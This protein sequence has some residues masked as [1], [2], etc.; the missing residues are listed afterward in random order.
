MTKNKIFDW[1]QKNRKEAD[2]S[3]VASHFFQ[4]YFKLKQDGAGQSHQRLILI[5]EKPH[6]CEFIEEVFEQLIET[7]D[8]FLLYQVVPSERGEGEGEKQRTR[9]LQ[10]LQ[11]TNS[12]TL[13]V[14]HD[15]ALEEKVPPLSWWKDSQE[16][17]Q[18]FYSFLDLSRIL[19]NLGFSFVKG[20]ERFAKGCVRFSQKACWI[21]P[22][23]SSQPLVVSKNMEGFEFVSPFNLFPQ[24][25]IPGKDEILRQENDW[26]E[27]FSSRYSYFE[28]EDILQLFLNNSSDRWRLYLQDDLPFLLKPFQSFLSEL[29]GQSLTLRWK[30]LKKTPSNWFQAWPGQK[31]RS[32]SPQKTQ[33]KPEQSFFPFYFYEELR[34]AFLVLDE[35]QEIWIRSRGLQ[36]GKAHSWQLP[37]D[38]ASANQ[39]LL[40]DDYS[41][42]LSVGDSVIHPDYGVARFRGLKTL[43]LNHQ[44]LDFLLLEFDE[45][46]KLSLS[47]IELAQFRRYLPKEQDVKLDS[48]R[49]SQWKKRLSRVRKDLKV[50]VESVLKHRQQ[51]LQQNVE[52][53]RFQE[54]IWQE[55]SEQFPHQLTACQE[56]AIRDVLADFESGRPMLRLLAGDVGFGKTEVAWQVSYAVMCHQ[57]QVLLLAP[58]TVL[59]QQHFQ[60]AQERFRDTGV[61]IGLLTGHIKGKQKEE[62]FQKLAH[63]EIDLLIATHSV[64]KKNISFPALSLLIVDEEHKFGVQQKEFLYE[65]FPL[66]HVLSMSATPIPRTLSLALSGMMDLSLLRTPPK[67]RKAIVNVIGPFDEKKVAEALQT[68]FERGGQSFFVSPRIMDLEKRE[69]WLKLLLPHLK[70]L[71]VHGDLSSDLI[72]SRMEDF[73]KGRGDVLLSTILIEAGMDFPRANTIVID[74]SEY[75]GLAQLYQLRGR[76]GRRQTQAY[77]YI[78]FSP[79]EDASAKTKVEARLE[80]IESI[81]EIGQGFQLALEDLEIRGAGTPDGYKQ[82]GA[83]KGIDLKTTWTVLQE[84]LSAR[85]PEQF[86]GQETT[87]GKFPFSLSLDP[88]VYPDSEHRLDLYQKILQASSFEKLRQIKKK[89]LKEFSNFHSSLNLLICFREFQLHFQTLGLSNLSILFD[90][91]LVEWKRELGEEEK[92]NI[93]LRLSQSEDLRV[94]STGSLMFLNFSEERFVFD[95]AEGLQ[96]FFVDLQSLFKPPLRINNASKFLS[97]GC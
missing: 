89:C 65:Q 69:K 48:L 46:D 49:K 61:R 38:I 91:A 62:L 21:W 17:L 64:V 94:T 95:P 32:S 14:T 78:F 85:D 76:V 31:E 51:R 55:F 5:C 4:T 83:L 35:K 79:S 53:I 12:F 1:I 96:Q 63:H 57:K 60:S 67:S 72:Q 50:V 52:P 37:S 22:L 47:M 66:I 84:E 54:E 2:L 45:E 39:R 58:T 59:A 25:Q 7:S 20:E 82:S 19:M 29:P 8:D 93:L 92:D 68:E 87:F 13:L 23:T 28:I 15:L 81:Q 3:T 77:A 42:N 70:F 27:S 75:L 44:E 88:Q 30:D 11:K 90:G 18:G 10:A 97:S 6:Q 43:S 9:C 71:K 26:I 41:Q 36:L 80:A 34:C 56:K 86:Q 74:R 16:T 24:R 40:L 33:L 73:R